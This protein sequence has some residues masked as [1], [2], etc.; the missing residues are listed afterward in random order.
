MAIVAV[1]TISTMLSVLV[2]KKVKLRSGNVRAINDILSVPRKFAAAKQ[3]LC[4]GFC[5]GSW[6]P[7]L[8]E[9]YE[10]RVP[11]YRFIQR[12]GDMVWLSPGV[13]HWVQSLVRDL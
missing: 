2:Y 8:E 9:L 3:M 1:A 11:V 12:P 10:E 6:W 4:F 13:V 7:I 5:E